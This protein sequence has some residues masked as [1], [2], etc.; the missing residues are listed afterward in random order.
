MVRRFAKFQWTA[1][2]CTAMAAVGLPGCQSKS[3]GPSKTSASNDAKA[4]SD[5]GE[6]KTGPKIDGHVGSGP[7]IELEPQPTQEGSV[8][9][10]KKAASIPAE[11]VSV[12]TTVTEPTTDATADKGSNPIVGNVATEAERNQKIAEDWPR[13]QFVLYVSGQQQGYIEPC[14]CTGLESQKGG[15]IRRDTLI[16]SLRGRGWNVIPVDVGNQ[17]RDEKQDGPPSSGP[18]PMIKFETTAQALQMMDYQAVSLGANDLVLSRVDLLQVAGS[19]EGNN[20]PFISANVT[21]YDLP[22]FFPPFKIIDA[23]S[24]KIGV[25]SVIGKEFE[26]K[27]IKDPSESEV[28]FSDPYEALKSVVPQ[29]K[30]QGCDFVVLLAHA[31]IEESAE[32]AKSVEGIDLV[33][34]AGGFGEPTLRAE[35]IEGSKAKMVQVG[36]KGQYGGIVGVFDDA[37]E[38]IR[39][40]KIAISSQFKDSERMLQLFTEYQKRL[41][42]AGFAKLGLT[43]ALHPTG[44]HFVSSEKCGECHTSAYDVWKE[45]PHFHATDSIVAANNDRGGIARHFDPECISCHVTGWVPQRFAPYQTGYESLEKTPH[46]VGSGC[47]NCHGPGSEHVKAEEDGSDTATDKQKELRQEMIL[48]LARAEVKCLE[49]HDIDNSPD[50]HASGAFEKYWERVKHYGKN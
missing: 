22:D 28:K 13:P 36:V 33:V 3:N 40:Q 1:F 23:G 4:T 42:E 25:T 39:Y 14:G 12:T 16:N 6:N 24:R 31:S 38:P 10:D 41:K 35:S 37:K 18:Q 34:T 2:L 44:K 32:L 17:N 11:T 9:T 19:A 48:P 5:S 21:V 49:C 27:V 15:L 46:L 47:E 29:L 50:F 30:S 45:S 43:P 26:K 20:R 7:V 8:K